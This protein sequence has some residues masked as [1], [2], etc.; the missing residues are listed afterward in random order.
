MAQG[1]QPTF[2]RYLL[3][4]MPRRWFG[5][6]PPVV[7]A[8][9]TGISTAFSELYSLLQFFKGQARLLTA[10]GPWLDAAAADYLGTR[11]YRAAGETDTAF[12][13]R[14]RREILRPRVTRA[15][16]VQELVDLTG[17]TP[18][19]FEPRNPSDTGGYGSPTL[20]YGVR[21]GYGSLSL[22]FQFFITA[23]RPHVAGIPNAPGYGSPL[24][25]YGVAPEQYV[26]VSQLGGVTDSAI[27]SAIVSVIPAATVAWTQI[28]NTPPVAGARL[29]VNFI[30]DESALG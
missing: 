12:R 10:T 8:I 20:G 15:A 28:T 3:A 2:L 6:A 17:Q 9:L 22:S 30:L 1:D 21:G 7:T 27:Y 26:G 11:V 23:Y 25:G 5:D 18:A 13:A 16:L 19:V 29:D 14:A 4:Q 24:G